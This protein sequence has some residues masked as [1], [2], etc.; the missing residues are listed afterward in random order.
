MKDQPPGPLAS[1]TAIPDK[2][3]AAMLAQWWNF[4]DPAGS[5][6]RF[7]A[8]LAD[9]APGSTAHTEIRTQIAR[10]LGLQ[11][12]L[13]E[14]EAE[15]DE[16][17]AAGPD[18][19]Q[20]RAREGLERG[21]LFNSAG[22]P[23][24]A[25]PFFRAAVAAA[26][27]AGDDFLLVDALHMLGIADGYHSDEWMRRALAITVASSEPQTRSWLGPLRNN[28]GWNLHGRGEFSAALEQFEGAR[29][30]YRDNGTARQQQVA[31]WA[32]GR[33]LRSLRRYPEALAVQ[34]Y[35]VDQDPDGYVYEELA[36]LLLLSGETEASSPYFTL[37][38]EM[39]AAD[40]W[41]DDP[42][43]VARLRQLGASVGPGTP[44]PAD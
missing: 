26:E 16:A 42:D 18:N 19:A 3:D 40:Q 15:L 17:V 22:R 33:A 7:R 10:A 5:A 8:R 25:I 9:F 29:D 11:S 35:L 13:A 24:L 6:D 43:R 20:V 30:A 2:L 37:A 1:N 36:E 28:F 39:L 44:P 14:A 27:Q 23:E 31:D 32:V 12:A 4:G 21:R 41:L 38:A 34:R